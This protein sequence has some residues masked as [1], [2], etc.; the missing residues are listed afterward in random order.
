[1]FYHKGKKVIKPMIE[2][3]MSPLSLA[4]L[5]SDDG[6]FAKPGVR[7]AVNCF[8]L[9]EVELLV[10]ILKR[11]FKLECTIQTLKPSGNYSIYIIGSSVPA[12]IKIVLPY[13]PPSMKYKL[14]L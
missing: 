11:K 7:L 10:Q 12:L 4:I 8:S 6:C 2:N 9:E 1:M 14:G 3:Y 5:I 13:M